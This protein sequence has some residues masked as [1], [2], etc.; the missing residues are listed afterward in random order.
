MNETKLALTL[1]KLKFSSDGEME[2]IL[3]NMGLSSIFH[4]A[5]FSGISSEKGKKYQI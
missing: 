2:R 1:P 4:K 3:R 5:N